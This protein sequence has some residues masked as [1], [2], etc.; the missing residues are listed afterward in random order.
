MIRM[1]EGSGIVVANKK[2]RMMIPGPVEV[3]P[4]VL[5]AMGSAVEPHYGDAWV[6]KQQRVTEILKE[7]FNTAGDVYLLVGSGTC[8][9]DAAIGSCLQ[10]GEKIL[11]GT[12]GY[13]GDR[14]V[15]IAKHNGLEVIEVKAAW[16]EEL[17]ADEI[18]RALERDPSIKAVAVV[19]S[20]T[21]TTVLNP[22][23]NI[24]PIV[25]KHGQL[26]IV[27]AVSSLGG[28]PFSM[29]EWCVDACATATQKCLGAPPGLG[30][31]AVNERAWK[32]IDR[33]QTGEHGWYTDL[34]VWRQY[35][36]EWG[37]WHP[38]P[39]TMATN[40]VNALLVSLTQLKAE[41][42]TKRMERYRSLALQLREGMRKA[43]I[44]PFTPDE[45]LNPVLTAGVA[46]SGVNSAEI[47]RYFLQEYAIQISGGLGA[48]KAGI[49]RIGHMSPVMTSEDIELVCEALASFCRTRNL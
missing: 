5:K 7:I 31:I 26:F 11:V 28:V 27:D 16:G 36:Q 22:I 2:I 10:G 30:P 29:D 45:K 4:D 47:V 13:F 3:H 39:V 9:I 8:A 44:A 33:L 20:E 46:P 38:T 49:F 12:N 35:A 14:L 43:G 48:L 18:E 19:H 41:G 21:S 42:I 25:R 34:R 40:N 1:K 37:D 24:G 17:D 32:S 23:Q 6:A 15:S